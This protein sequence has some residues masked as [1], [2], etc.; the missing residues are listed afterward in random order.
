MLYGGAFMPIDL[1]ANLLTLDPLNNPIVVSVEVAV[2]RS[3]AGYL[4]NMSKTGWQMFSLKKFIETVL[5]VIP[6]A[7]GLNALVPGA[8]VGALVTDYILK[9]ATDTKAK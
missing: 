3:V 9:K 8:S 5:R 6:Q 2:V 1:I 7:I 4:E